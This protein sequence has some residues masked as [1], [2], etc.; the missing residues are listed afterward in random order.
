MVWRL[1]SQLVG[2][3]KMIPFIVHNCHC[4][5]H[6]SIFKIANCNFTEKWHQPVEENVVAG[7]VSLRRRFALSLIVT[8]GKWPTLR[9]ACGHVVSCTSCLVTLSAYVSQSFFLWQLWWI[10]ISVRTAGNIYDQLIMIC[11][12][13]WLFPELSRRKSQQICTIRFISLILWHKFWAVI[14]RILCIS[15]LFSWE[16]SGCHRHPLS[17]KCISSIVD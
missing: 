11:L 12:M 2:T 4:S 16:E 14:L 6:L 10:E 1:N 3:K 8:A 5:H 13:T 9:N 7:T 15:L 17:I